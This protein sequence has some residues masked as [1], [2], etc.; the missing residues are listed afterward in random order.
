MKVSIIIPAYNEEK[1]LPRTLDAVLRWANSTQ[2]N[3][4]VIV[5]DDGSK[6]GTRSICERYADNSVHVISYTPNKGKGNAL[7]VG[8]LNASGDVVLTMDA[9]LCVPMSDSE[10][11]LSALEKGAD[12]AIGSRYV[13]G[14]VIETRQPLVRQI[15]GRLFNLLVQL[16]CLPGIKDSQCGFKAYRT[17]VARVLYTRLR[18]QGYVQDVEILALAT[19]LGYRIAEVG[20]TWNHQENSKVSLIKDSLRMLHELLKIRHSVTSV[21]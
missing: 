6:D 19:R 3:A 1:R 16:T 10:K 4:E 7:R 13:R 17:E 21:E 18:S 15:A 14:S 12:I 20:V 11:L 8:V 2:T 9:D 5:V